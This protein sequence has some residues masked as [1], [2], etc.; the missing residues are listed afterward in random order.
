MRE[1]LERFDELLRDRD[2]PGCLLAS[3]GNVRTS[4]GL[5]RSRLPPCIVWA[6]DAAEYR[7]DGCASMSDAPKRFV[8]LMGAAAVGDPV[9]EAA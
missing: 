7:L 3:E 6:D 4:C 1:L 5:V 8:G 2:S 9:S